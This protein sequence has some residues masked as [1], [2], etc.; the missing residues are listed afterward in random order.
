[1]WYV[2]L[3][4][5]YTADFPSLVV[6]YP[7]AL[8]GCAD[9]QR[10]LAVGMPN[11]FPVVCSDDCWCCM[12]YSLL[13]C[14]MPM[15]RWP[16]YCG[17]LCQCV[18]ADT[19][20]CHCACCQPSPTHTTPAHHTPPPPTPDPHPPPTHPH[21]PWPAMSG[22]QLLYCV[23]CVSN[24]SDGVNMAVILVFM[25]TLQCGMTLHPHTP[26]P[27]HAHPTHDQ[28]SFVWWWSYSYPAPPHTPLGCVPPI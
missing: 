15:P 24:D 21:R 9:P 22:K 25:P 6:P 28:P 2:P 4:I 27:P 17:I 1:M 19:G 5:Y 26:P 8:C 16:A 13:Y 11:P 10:S 3:P 23:P 12:Y 7:S 20:P 14:L 18:G